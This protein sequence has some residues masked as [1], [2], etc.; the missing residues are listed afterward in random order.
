MTTLPSPRPNGKLSTLGV[1]HHRTHQ[2][3]PNT[4]NPP[5]I[6]VMTGD[7]K[8]RLETP[9]PGRPNQAG[10]HRC[11]GRHR[12]PNGGPAAAPHR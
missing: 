4:A 2:A 1:K 10:E 6:N 7:H 5:A 3:K 8:R 12:Q 9:P 11:L